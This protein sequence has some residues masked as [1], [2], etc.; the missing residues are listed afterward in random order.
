MIKKFL[1]FQLPI[2]WVILSSLNAGDISGVVH[3]TQ[4]G[5]SIIGVNVFIQSSGRGAAT[6]LAGFFILRSAGEGNVSLTLSHIAYED[7]TLELLLGRQNHFISMIGLRPHA[8][9]T[10]AVEVI[11]QRSS[12]I[13]DMD[14]SSLQ[15]DPIVSAEEMY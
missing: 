2:S 1:K 5:E 3:D 15:V 4:T 10:K 14:I 7:T 9:D 12:I 13:E 8:L 6:D 11:G